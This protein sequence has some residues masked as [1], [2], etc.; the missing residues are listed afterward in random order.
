MSFFPWSPPLSRTSRGIVTDT[1]HRRD[2]Q[3]TILHTLLT[4]LSHSHSSTSSL[5]AYSTS[6][7]GIQPS[8]RRSVRHA[9]FEGPLSP[10]LLS[11]AE[12][13]SIVGSDII[14]GLELDAKGWAAYVGS[15]ERFRKELKVVFKLEED[16]TRVK[17]DREILVSRLIKTTKKRP[18]KSDLSE[19]AASY[20]PGTN[21]SSRAS[22]SSV[23]S[24]GSNVSKEGKRATK[25]AD[26]Q[27]ELLGCEEHLASLEVAIE[28]ERNKV[29]LH[30]LEERFR[31]ME[32]VGRMWIVQARKGLGDLGKYSGE[33]SHLFDSTMLILVRT[34]RGCFR[35]R[36]E[37]IL[38]AFSVCLSVRDRRRAPSRRP[39][40]SNACAR[41]INRR[42]HRR[43]GG[44][45]FVGR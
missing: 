23:T 14:D 12:T 36:L 19:I 9:A 7:P 21:M 13:G 44:R 40:P 17:R 34:A 18:T 43:R 11:N 42:K 33:S 24:G 29:L 26:A 25:L 38:V 5:L 28:R 31:A 27:A 20:R 8:I 35:G 1:F 2:T 37:P 10:L 30:G 45:R 4:L 16:I 3:K 22:M 15:L 41:W 6:S 39:I 32:A